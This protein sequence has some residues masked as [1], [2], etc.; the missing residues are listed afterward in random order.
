MNLIPEIVFVT[1]E[2][3]SLVERL[4][5]SSVNKEYFKIINRK[6]II[7]HISATMLN[8]YIKLNFPI[9]DKRFLKEDIKEFMEPKNDFNI[10]TFIG[11]DILE[12]YNIHIYSQW[13]NTIKT[14][15]VKNFVKSIDIWGSESRIIKN[16]RICAVYRFRKLG[17]S[18]KRKETSLT[19]KALIF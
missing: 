4:S 18:K 7:S 10:L 12:Q 5:W 6:N 9:S 3:L 8:H 15:K 11:N 1:E 16:Q 17:A 2:Y 13:F 14:Y 19:V